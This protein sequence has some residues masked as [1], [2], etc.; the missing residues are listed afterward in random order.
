MKFIY[1][2][3]FQM[4]WIMWAGY[5][6]S[7]SKYNSKHIYRE[8]KSSRLLHIIPLGIA[9][10]LLI[11]PNNTIQWLDFQ[12]SPSNEREICFWFGIILTIFGLGFTV[13]ARQ[14]LGK[15]W[16]GIVTIKEEHKLITKG[17]YQIV[18]NPMY[19]GLL[20]A[21]IGTAIARGNMQALIAICIVIVTLLRKIKIEE[22]VLLSQFGEVFLRYKTQTKALIPLI[23]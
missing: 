5:W 21:F 17:P 7:A 4:T 16:S 9:F 10:L 6:W 3:L 2:Y 11:L 12:I 18:R 22:H 13:W 19:S 20:L 8:S 15:N 23:Y 14:Y 1:H